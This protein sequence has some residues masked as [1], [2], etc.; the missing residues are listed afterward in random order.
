MIDEQVK[1]VIR[2]IMKQSVKIGTH[3]ADNWPINDLDWRSYRTN[4]GK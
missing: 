3:A 2:G 4:I 1:L